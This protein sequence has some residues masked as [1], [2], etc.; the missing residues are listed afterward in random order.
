MMT[1]YFILGALIVLT[2]S[3]TAFFLWGFSHARKNA[4]AERQEEERRKLQSE[5]ELQKE[6]ENIMQEVFDDAEE[7][8]ASLSA[9]TGR[10]S[11]DA[12]NNSLHERPKN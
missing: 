5:H 7:K 9:G 11:F 6:K 8:K 2:V 4:E 12:I 10:A 3:H 1:V